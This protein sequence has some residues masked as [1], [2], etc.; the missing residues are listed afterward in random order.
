MSNF[1]GVGAAPPLGK[2]PRMDSAW[3]EA[4]LEEEGRESGVFLP[5]HFL[6]RT[7][8]GLSAR[9]GERATYSFHEGETS[10]DHLAADGAASV[11]THV[12]G[13]SVWFK[14]L[15]RPRVPRPVDGDTSEN[16]VDKKC[17]LSRVRSQGGVLRFSLDGGRTD[18][19]TAS[20]HY[21]SGCQQRRMD[22]WGTGERQ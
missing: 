2:W 7:K 3:R 5:P 14:V 15:R 10:S 19:R 11:L 6:R 13:M 18:G 12:P 8:T 20:L 17:S 4:G 1:R 16:S 9:A 22:F 21:C